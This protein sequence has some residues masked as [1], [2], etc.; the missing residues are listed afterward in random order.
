MANESAYYV[1]ALSHGSIDIDTWLSTHFLVTV[2]AICFSST[3]D[4]INSAR[5]ADS[6]AVPTNYVAASFL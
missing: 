5:A 6:V 4:E 1:T 3:E 2:I